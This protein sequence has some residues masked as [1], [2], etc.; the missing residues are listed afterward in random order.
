MHYAIHILMTCDIV[1]ARDLLS[2]N[3]SFITKKT[4]VVNWLARTLP[5]QHRSLIYSK[6]NLD[7]S[8]YI[9]KHALIDF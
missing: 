5:L 9:S 8:L 3:Y 4:I 6:E 1:I 7:L 2:I